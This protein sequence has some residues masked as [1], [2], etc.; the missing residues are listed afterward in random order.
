MSNGKTHNSHAGL[1]RKK[2]SGLHGP[3]TNEP[4]IKGKKGTGRGRGRGSR[5]LE[6]RPDLKR[7]QGVATL[8]RKRPSAKQVRQHIQTSRTVTAIIIFFKGTL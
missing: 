4:S 8:E 2:G 3:V 5:L 6:D 1:G 7:Q